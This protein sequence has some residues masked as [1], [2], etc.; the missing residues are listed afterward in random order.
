MKIQPSKTNL[1]LIASLTAITPLVANSIKAEKI[2][3]LLIMTDQQ[4][5]DAVGYAG[6]KVI[7]TPNLDR[8]A[9]EGVNFSQAIT[10]C[11]VSAP[12]RTSILTGKL[13]EATTIRGNN[14]IHSNDC[15]YPTFDEIL[16]KKGYTAEYHGKFHS[17]E[18]MANVYANPAINGISGFEQIVK[19]EQN[20]VKF[21]DETFKK[22][23][24]KKNELYETSFY[25]GNIPYKPD[26]TD[27]KYDMLQ[28]GKKSDIDPNEKRSQADVHG[29]LDLAANYT[30][31]A[32]QGQ[33]TIQALERLKDKPFILTASFHCPHVPITPSEPYASM[34]EP[35]DLI[36]YSSISDKRS[37][38]PYQPNIDNAPYND[39]A[40]VQYMMANYYAFVTEIDDWVGKILNKLDVLNL[41]QNTLVIFVSDHGEMLGAHGMRGKFCFYE[42]S[43]RVPFLMRF[44]GKIPQGKTITTPVS[45]LNIFPTILD[46]AGLKNIPS[47]GYSMR[48][49]MEG[50]ATPK[51]DFAI[52][53]WVWTNESVPSLMIR[54]EDWKLMTTHRTGGKNV[55]VL[56]DLKNDPQEINNLLGS[57]PERFKYKEKAEEMRTKLVGYLK[58]VNSPLTEGVE[59]R[60]LIRE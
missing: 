16:T 43:V 9:S 41:S 39:K 50:K 2:N 34:Y 20:Y 21:L 24:L 37:N 46:Y 60:I 26:P 42:E 8:L 48:E 12:A 13:L 59:K 5:W 27:S 54:T 53:E 22:R 19:W 31:T 4:S 45:I 44:P 33:N 29:V 6:N 17:P 36:P 1:A 18:Y 3:I 40:K 49:I 15:F 56:Y 55:E 35:K 30:I 14:D 25:G 52:S 11:P 28:S 58:D 7:K 23:P 32:I 38:S 10:A 47:D 51:Y 57:N